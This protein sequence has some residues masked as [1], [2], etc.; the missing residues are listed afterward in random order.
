M[1]A[2]AEA[3]I[4]KGMYQFRK[5]RRRQEGGTARAAAGLGHHLPRSHR[6]RRPAEAG[7]G[8]R[9]RPVGLP[10]FNELAR[11]GHDVQ[12]WNMLH[13]AEKPRSPHVKLAQRR[14][15]ARSSRRPDYIRLFADQIRPSSIVAM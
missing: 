10:S 8:R 3:D 2:G 12:R 11:N 1:P 7:L 6:R 15:P 14:A 13:P 5:G 4:L 9:R